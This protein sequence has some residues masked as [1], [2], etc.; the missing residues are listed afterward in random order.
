MKSLAVADGVIMDRIYI[1]RH[2]ETKTIKG[3]F[4]SETKASVLLDKLGYF[5]FEMYPWGIQ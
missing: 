1:V 4:R 5:D 2:I 3:I